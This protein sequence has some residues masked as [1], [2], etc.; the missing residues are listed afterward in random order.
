MKPEG[1]NTVKAGV[2]IGTLA[3]GILYLLAGLAPSFFISGS[4]A[5]MILSA[6]TGGPVEPTVIMRGLIVLFS[7]AGM[8]VVAAGFL[9]AGGAAGAVLGYVAEALSPSRA[10]D[11]GE[12]H[13]AHG[14]H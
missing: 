8:L 3:G 10:T 5:L 1:K 14:K 2:K 6:L 4:G 7:V 12:E 13:A 9:M 11:A